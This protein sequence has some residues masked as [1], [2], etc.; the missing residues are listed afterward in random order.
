MGLTKY[1]EIE[2]HTTPDGDVLIKPS[3]E[4]YKELIESNYD[5][6]NHISERI[7][8]EY[9]EA[10]DELLS[11]YAKSNK[12]L[13]YFK[14]LYVRRFIKCNFANHDSQKFD[15]DADGNFNFEQVHC[16]LRGECRSY[17]IICSPKRT[18]KLTDKELIILKMYCAPM[19]I[20][21]IAEQLYIS[22]LT[23]ETHIKN[24]RKKL[25]LHS[26]AELMKYVNIN[27]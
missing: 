24:I 19:D 6:I 22:I 11:V 12:N 26:K 21:E 23:A 3:S 15:I 10:Y 5:F 27:L 8:N 14:F 1:T 18:T 7:K 16:P 25:D 20:K 9:T 2:F 17:G 13:S 4:N